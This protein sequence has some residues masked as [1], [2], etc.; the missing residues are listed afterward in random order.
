MTACQLWIFSAVSISR[1]WI[2]LRISTISGSFSEISAIF[3][4]KKTRRK[5]RRCRPGSGKRK[6]PGCGPRVYGRRRRRRRAWDTPL[7]SGGR[8]QIFDTY[9]PEGITEYETDSRSGKALISDDTQMT[10]FTA[11]GLLAGATRGR[12]RGIAGPPREYVKSAYYDWLKTQQSTMREVNRHERYTEEGGVSWLLDVRNCI[13]AGAWEHLSGRS[14]GRRM[15]TGR[16]ISEIL[17]ITARAAA[18]L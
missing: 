2:T 15:I 7:S 16:T 9:G 12:M 3:T 1:F 18:V 10:L 6:T 11:N 13:P 14:D 8:K 17:R 5:I 4:G